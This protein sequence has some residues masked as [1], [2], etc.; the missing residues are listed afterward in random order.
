MGE[1]DISP[2]RVPIAKI[3]NAIVSKL[4][5]HEVRSSIDACNSKP[6]IRPTSTRQHELRSLPI[7]LIRN[8]EQRLSVAQATYVS[9]CPCCC[10]SSNNGRRSRR[11]EVGH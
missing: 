4:L 1:H 10:R 11:N 2:K 6:T 9:D 8:L 3:R 7:V 5:L